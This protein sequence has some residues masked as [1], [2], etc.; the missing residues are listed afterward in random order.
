MHKNAYT[1]LISLRYSSAWFGDM[2][3]ESGCCLSGWYILCNSVMIYFY[4]SFSHVAN[5]IEDYQRVLR[6]TR[7][8]LLVFPTSST[9]YTLCGGLGSA[10]GGGV[11]GVVALALSGGVVAGGQG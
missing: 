4:L 5:G 2:P 7:E 11:V 10:L 3:V 1:L 9:L 6:I 8:S